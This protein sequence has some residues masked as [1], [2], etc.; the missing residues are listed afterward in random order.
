MCEPNKDHTNNNVYLVKKKKKKQRLPKYTRTNMQS[1][2]KKVKKQY[3]NLNNIIRMEHG[4]VPQYMVLTIP[5]IT[6][7][8][9]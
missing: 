9:I 4:S 6:E 5:C 8:N 7:H 2:R 3:I 1:S